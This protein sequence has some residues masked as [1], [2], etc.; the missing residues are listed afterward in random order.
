MVV[1]TG[2]AAASRQAIGVPVFWGMLIGTVFGL[3]VIPLFY[4]L[5]QTLFEKFEKRYKK[6]SK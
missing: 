6:K 1:A 4:V 3:F 2:A 5:V